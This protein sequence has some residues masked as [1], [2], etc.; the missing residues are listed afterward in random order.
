MGVEATTQRPL[1]VIDASSE[2]FWA[3][4]SSGQLLFQRCAACRRLRYPPALA[5]PTCSSF[6]FVVTE[7]SG[8]GTVYSYAIPR[9]PR[10]PFLDDGVAVVVVELDEGVRM[11]SNLIEF[12][13]AEIDFGM[14]VEVFY[15]PISTDVALPMFRPLRR[16][17]DGRV[18]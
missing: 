5:C 1:P 9:R 8:R 16:A 2:F 12:N 13:P 4:T 10:L 15:Q 17:T 14:P 6:E 3:G 7:S 11:L 18:G